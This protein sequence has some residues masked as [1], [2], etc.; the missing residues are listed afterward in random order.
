MIGFTDWL[1]NQQPD[2]DLG[3]ILKFVG[4]DNCWPQQ[5][6]HLH[7]FR[8]HIMEVHPDAATT[9]LT[10]SLLEAHSRFRTGRR[11]ALEQFVRGSTNTA[12][13]AGRAV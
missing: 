1:A 7:R 6:R 2:Q 12:T 3:P 13:A 9:D 11:E 10:A 8:A 4:S 5:G